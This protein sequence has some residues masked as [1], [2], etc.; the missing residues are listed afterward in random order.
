MLRTRFGQALRIAAQQ[1][2]ARTVVA[3]FQRIRMF[4]AEAAK[5]AKEET[6][7]HDMVHFKTSSNTHPMGIDKHPGSAPHTHLAPQQYLVLTH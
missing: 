3:P 4:S 2:G 6:V 7:S 5:E 1:T